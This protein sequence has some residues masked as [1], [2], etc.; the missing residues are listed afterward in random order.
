MVVRR[1]VCGAVQDESQLQEES[2]EQTEE[3]GEEEERN[4]NTIE[5]KK[6]QAKSKRQK[7]EGAG[8]SC[9]SFSSR[10]QQCR[11]AGK[12]KVWSQGLELVSSRFRK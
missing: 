12:V 8:A 11:R 2:K 10:L 9:G 1:Q 4:K 3:E 6:Q 5:R 7:K